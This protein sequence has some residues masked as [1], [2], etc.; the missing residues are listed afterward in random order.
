MVGATISTQ[1]AKMGLNQEQLEAA[2]DLDGHTLLLAGAGSGKTRVI[3]GRCVHLL[4]SGVDP[5]RLLVLTFTRNAAR[6]LKERLY[7]QFG[8]RARAVH[9]CTFHTFA[10][11]IIHKMPR[12]FGTGW[13]VI[14][15]DD[16]LQIMRLLRGKKNKDLPTAGQLL[17][18]YSFARNVCV[19]IEQHIEQTGQV[20]ESIKPEVLQIYRD[21]AARKRDRRY[22]DYDDILAMLA[23]KM[24][25]D[26]KLRGVI[27]SLFDH[28]MVDEMQ[29][30]NPLQWRL[31]DMLKD[32]GRLFCV[33]DDAQSIYAFRG[34]DFRNVHS[35]TERVAGAKVRKLVKNYRSTQEILDVSNWLLEQSPLAYDKRLVAHRGQGT[36]PTLLNFPYT[37]MEASWLVNDLKRRY[38][39][40]GAAW[41]EHM[42][43]VRSSFIARSIEYALIAADVPYRYVGGTK[44]MESAH[45][46]DVLSLMRIVANYRDELGWIRYLMLYPK[47]GEVTAVKLIDAVLGQVTLEDGVAAL[48]QEAKMPA[49]A[50]QGIKSVMGYE[51]SPV[52]ALKKSIEIMEPILE[53]RY[54]P[55]WDRRKNDFTLVAK[56]AAK[57][58]SII[59]MI[60]EYLLDPMTATQV[61]ESDDT[62]VVTL[63]TIHSAK[64]TEAPVCYLP[65][66]EPGNYPHTR[67]L[68]SEDE[69]E[70]E[71]RILYVAMTRAQN[72]LIIS[73]SG[74]DYAA[75]PGSAQGKSK[76]LDYGFEFAHDEH[77]QQQTYFLSGLPNLLCAE[78]WVAPGSVP[79]F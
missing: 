2:T 59:E 68:G 18:M 10:I 75:P 13:Q 6:E 60:E 38:T 73:R 41:R 35:F 52:V 49:S 71:R 61:E 23:A 50:M 56:L 1:L 8:E 22:L 55:D 9:A 53:E 16:Q 46:R 37:D 40:E 79:R 11:G 34:A 21:Y 12:I 76:P 72:E 67:S 65:L 62:D 24:A 25:Q 77:A 44:L 3:I 29:D 4:A 43:L 63:I 17:S 19:S 58:G 33:G 51:K 28:I 39:E 66:C 57:H 42:I 36:K 14:D 15:A 69:V 70:E 64:G 32:P 7:A 74:Y 30:T 31:L 27:G 54:R 48:A 78:H 5:S 45:V 20:D 26:E 47:I